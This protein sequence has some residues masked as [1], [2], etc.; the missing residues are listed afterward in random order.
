MA[1]KSEDV[2]GFLGGATGII[3]LGLFAYWLMWDSDAD[4]MVDQVKE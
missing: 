1:L 3:V 2:L 4:K